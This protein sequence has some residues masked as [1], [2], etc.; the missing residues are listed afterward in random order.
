MLACC[1]K[2]P[3]TVAPNTIVILISNTADT[4]MDNSE[5]D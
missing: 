2:V 3:V 4:E 1:G 5:N